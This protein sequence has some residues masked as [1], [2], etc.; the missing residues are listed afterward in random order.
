MRHHSVLLLLQQYTKVKVF[1]VVFFPYIFNPQLRI[2]LLILRGRGR[3]VS[4]L[5]PIRALTRYRTRN[6]LGCGTGCCS[7]QRS[8]P[9]GSC[10][11][12]GA[13]GTCFPAEACRVWRVWGCRGQDAARSAGGTAV[14]AGGGASQQGQSLIQVLGPSVIQ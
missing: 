12:K 4:G 14:A 13:A 9:Q 3:N 2:H 6:L 7:N 10:I 8:H 11:P 5:P 1:C